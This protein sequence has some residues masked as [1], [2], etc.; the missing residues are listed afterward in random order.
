MSPW[1]CLLFQNTVFASELAR[2]KIT[3]FGVLIKYGRRVLS[4]TETF[5]LRS[6]PL[7]SSLGN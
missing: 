2:T 7:M 6:C 5:D 4:V 3:V 1:V